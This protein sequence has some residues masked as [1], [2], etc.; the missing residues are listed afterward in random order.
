MAI[1]KAICERAYPPPPE[2]TPADQGAFVHDCLQ[3]DAAARKTTSAL[4][5]SEWLR[6]LSGRDTRQAVFKWLMAAA[7]A[8]ANA[9]KAKAR[10][11]ALRAI[12]SSDEG[13]SGD[14]RPDWQE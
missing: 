14:P 12:A 2:G 9:T 4:I 6:P 8:A 1:C 10:E 3:I 13:L 7:A 5:E 11:M